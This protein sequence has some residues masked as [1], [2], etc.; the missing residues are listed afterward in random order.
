MEL[1]IAALEVEVRW[2]RQKR[3]AYLHT[4]PEFA[5]KKMLGAGFDQLFTVT[6]VFRNDEVTERHNI[7][8]SMLEFYEAGMD[9]VGMM[10]TTEALL[11]HCAVGFAL[12]ELGGV[13]LE[14]PFRRA[15]VADLLREH[16]QIDLDLVAV[17]D[18]GAFADAARRAGIV[19]PQDEPFDDV[20]NRVYL[21]K[22][23]AHLRGPIF[24]YDY[25]IELAVLARRNPLNPRYAERFELF[26]GDLELCNGFGELTDPVEQRARLVEEQQLRIARGLPGYP[27]DE[28][29]LRA[30]Q[31]M[32][33]C[34]GN[35]VGVDRLV[36]VMT[37]AK[38]IAEISAFSSSS[39]F[40]S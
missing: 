36:M 1:H 15:R 7:E 32:P 21:E 8:F 26:V 30:L 20:F 2:N 33:A 29:F 38:N 34:A 5:M 31:T 37:G 17:G 18:A 22:I 24:I 28:G 10:D 11:R 19:V 14:L 13:A 27:I 4:S 39:L 9:V 40:T 3:R 12:K 6:R 16:A 23:E 35:A 25:P